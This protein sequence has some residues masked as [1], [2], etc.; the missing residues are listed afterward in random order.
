MAVE[1]E[2]C[3]DPSHDSK[4]VFGG[5]VTAE[6]SHSADAQSPEKL[7]DTGTLAGDGEKTIDAPAATSTATDTP[8]VSKLPATS[9]DTA[10]ALPPIDKDST[11]HCSESPLMDPEK[12]PAN[13]NGADHVSGSLEKDSADK[14][15]PPPI[16]IPVIEPKTVDMGT[17]HE[18]EKSDNVKSH[19]K[20]PTD[21]KSPG[22]TPADANTEVPP[23]SSSQPPSSSVPASDQT[24]S[25]DP[26]PSS[27]RDP[28]HSLSRDSATSHV[29]TWMAF[30]NYYGSV[31]RADGTAQT[32]PTEFTFAN[33]PPAIASKP[34]SLVISRST[35]S[36]STSKNC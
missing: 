2:A 36:S 27:S 10:R 6:D 33:P 18:G 13:L 15:I 23:S 9:T 3:V 16:P 34:T 20:A 17:R 24:Q 26:P 22:E 21:V 29:S 19:D 14:S 7:S 12:Q 28:S 11:K 31:S 5:S 25:R 30:K 35:R 8:S 32:L 4:E 1:T